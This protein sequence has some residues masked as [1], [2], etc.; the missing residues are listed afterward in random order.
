MRSSVIFDTIA[1]FFFLLFAIQ[2]LV[3]AKAYGGLPTKA[4]WAMTRVTIR[5]PKVLL[6]VSGILGLFD[7]LFQPLLSSWIPPFPRLF[8]AGLS[9]VALNGACLPPTVLYLAASKAKGFSLASELQFSIAPLKIVHLLDTFQAGAILG[10]QLHQSEFRVG[11][12]WQKAVRT[13][14]E[15]TPLI[16]VDG[17]VVTEPILQEITHI[18]NSGLHNR[19]FFVADETG[20]VPALSCLTLPRE[21]KLQIATSQQLLSGLK[22]LGWKVLSFSG[23]NLHQNVKWN[24]NDRVGLRSVSKLSPF[25][26]DVDEMKM[27]EVVSKNFLGRPTRDFNN[28]SFYGAKCAHFAQSLRQ[29]TLGMVPEITKQTMRDNPI[30]FYFASVESTLLK[31]ANSLSEAGG[32]LVLMSIGTSDIEGIMTAASKRLSR[33][34]GVPTESGTDT[35]G[36]TPAQKVYAYIATHKDALKELTVLYN[37]GIRMDIPNRDLRDDF[38]KMLAFLRT[39][40][41][42]AN[43]IFGSH[44][45]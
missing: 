21:A 40:L 23:R 37:K 44:S 31:L 9:L 24:L 14:S 36:L 43:Q 38:Q 33:V 6:L 42:I 20:G 34:L 29:R 5:G 45:L 1:V 35:T 8:L 7:S 19:T 39:E 17:R 16:I 32:I 27:S 15:I 2:I 18:L 13:F 3:T 28:Y 26:L 12:N 11:A 41:E 25:K 22:G 30:G 4:L 10:D